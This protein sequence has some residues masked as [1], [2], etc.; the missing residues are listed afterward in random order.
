METR[1]QLL[2]QIFCGMRIILSGRFLNDRVEARRHGMTVFMI[3]DSGSV[4]YTSQCKGPI[5]INI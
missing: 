4:T 1:T 5:C 2:G 3:L